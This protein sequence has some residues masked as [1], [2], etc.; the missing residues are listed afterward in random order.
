MTASLT[1]AK[2]SSSMSRH[3]KNPIQ[4]FSLPN[5]WYLY[6]SQSLL[7][8]FA[9]IFSMIPPS[10]GQSVSLSPHKTSANICFFEASLEATFSDFEHLELYSSSECFIFIKG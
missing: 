8:C 6:N 7:L 1:N 9:K 4:R 3:Q 5:G 10:F 2:A